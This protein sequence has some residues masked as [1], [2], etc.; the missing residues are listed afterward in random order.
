MSKVTTKFLKSTIKDG[1]FFDESTKHKITEVNGEL[2]EM[3]YCPYCRQW[4]TL[5]KFNP[6]KNQ[7][8]GYIR[9]CKHCTTVYRQ[10]RIERVEMEQEEAEQ[11]RRPIDYILDAVN[12]EI[13]TQKEIANK[14][15]ISRSY[16]S[17]IEKRALLKLYFLL[18]K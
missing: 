4:L 10:K 18:K 13:E 6:S 1:E 5:D 17:R 15:N 14:L 16:V 3:K 12:R 8:D 11:E 7:Y 2:V 9:T